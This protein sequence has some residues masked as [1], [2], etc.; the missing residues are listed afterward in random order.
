MSVSNVS[1][2]MG[3]IVL[4]LFSS[5]GPSYE[6]ESYHDI[7]NGQWAYEDT[8]SFQFNIEDTLSIYNLYLELE[9]SPTFSNQNLYTQIHT[10]FPE[11]QRLT[12]M[13]SL[14]LSDNMTGSWQGKCNK[15]RCTLQIPIQEGA[16]FNQIGKH[17]ITIE[18]YMR[19]SPV[20]GVYRIGFMLEDTG[21][22]RG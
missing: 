2:L 7:E 15:E 18:Q 8:L 16:Y 20:E 12:E 17:I 3:A 13:I 10:T 9:H 6:Y 11:R 19:K 5:C 1:F 21:Q 14:E 22:K 4:L